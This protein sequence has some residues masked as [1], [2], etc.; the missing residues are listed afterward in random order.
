MKETKGNRLHITFLGKMNTGKSSIINNL[1]NREISIVSDFAGTTTDVNQKAMELLPLGPVSILDTAGIDD[2][3]ELG[4]KR[5]NKTLEALDRTDVAVIIFDNT[6]VKDCD[7]ELFN[8]LKTKKIPIISIINKTDISLP[9]ENDIKIIENN[10]NHIIHASAKKDKDIASKIKLGLISV[11]D[12]EYID[13]PTLLGDVVDKNDTII[14]VIP[15]D[16]EAP[17]GRIILPQV[18]TIR[19]ILDNS[20]IS[21]VCN[22]QNLKH[23]IDSLK[24]PPRL[25]VTDSQAF[26]EVSEIVPKNIELTSFSIIFAKLKGDLKTFVHGAKTIDKLQDNDKVLICESCSHHPNEDDIGRVKIPNLIKKYTG[27]NIIF[28]HTSGHIFPNDIEKYK[29]IIHCGACMTN[30][31]EV[32]SR[33]EKASS[34]YVAITNYGVAIA[35]CLNIL[36][37]TLEPFKN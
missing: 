34:K 29:L 3:G 36:D 7:I 12:S 9:S 30:R 2:I 21:V 23:T 4:Q 22:V 14:L 25:V 15:I 16:K 32:L 27:K 33:I 37:R 24:K 17:K 31:R 19:D 35:K 18:Q 5:V 26:K 13:T 1:F 20:A 6:G 8:N 11:L 28:E 10:S